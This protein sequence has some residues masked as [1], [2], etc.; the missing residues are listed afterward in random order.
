M[1][2]QEE[3]K[4]VGQI[5]RQIRKSKNMTQQNLADAL[6]YSDRSTIA[7]IETG[8]TDITQSLVKRI[9]DALCV[10][11]LDILGIMEDDNNKQELLNVFALL[12][13]DQ[14]QHLIAYAKFL[15][16]RGDN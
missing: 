10:S 15:Q 8:K 11:P 4:R 9:A 3:V 16:D 14:Q 1:G 2:K 6:G 5:I 7:K 13:N 12:T